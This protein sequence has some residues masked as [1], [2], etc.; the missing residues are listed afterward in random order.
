MN[1][2][3]SHLN[4]ESIEEFT[5]FALERSIEGLQQLI[6][7]STQCAEAIRQN[8]QTAMPRLSTLAVNLRDFDVFERDIGSLFGMDGTLLCDDRGSLQE[9]EEQFRAVLDRLLIH[10][11]NQEFDHLSRLLDQELPA[12]L[13]RFQDLLPILRE[14]IDVQYIQTAP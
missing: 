3:A 12:V 5:L 9:T 1:P 11:G 6:T 4:I 14:F 7:D 10:L 13:S 2:T 8:P